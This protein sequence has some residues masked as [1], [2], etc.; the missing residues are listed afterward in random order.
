MRKL[1]LG[2]PVALAMLTVV[3]SAGHAQNACIEQC[4]RE[5]PGSRPDEV[6]VRGWC[7]ILRGCWADAT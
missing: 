1:S 3:P 2:V 7:Y 5:F 6:A 4:N